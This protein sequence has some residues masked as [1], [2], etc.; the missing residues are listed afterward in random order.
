MENKAALLKDE[1]LLLLR[2]YEDFDAR[3]LTIKGW[4]ASIAIAAI[5]L[6]FQNRNPSLWLFAAAA[7]VVFW[8]LEGTWKSFQYA[9]RARIVEI[10]EAFR[11]DDFTQVVPFQTYGRWHAGW[12]QGRVR[13]V[14]G[15]AIVMVPHLLTAVAGLVLFLLRHRVLPA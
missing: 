7:S 2:F 5:G 11:R 13:E 10:E 8:L 14:L 6:G 3:L 9:Y 4:S 12:R 15:L 1:Y